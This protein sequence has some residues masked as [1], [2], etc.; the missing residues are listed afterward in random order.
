MADLSENI[1][2]QFV[3]H[4]VIQAE[5]L[6]FCRSLAEE[7]GRTLEQT[8]V[9]EGLISEAE[10]LQQYAQKLGMEFFEDLGARRVS[11]LFLN[12]VPLQFARQNALVGLMNGGGRL[13]VATS[14]PLELHPLDDLS[15]MLNV[16]FDTVLAT[17]PQIL[18][19]INQTY[20]QGAEKVGQMVEEIREEDISRLSAEISETEDLLDIANKAPV[21]KLVNTILSQANRN[22]AS[23][24][25][26]QPYEEKVVVRYRIDGLLDDYQVLPRKV[27]DAL[28]SR[29]KV[30]GRMDIAE[31]RFPQDGRATVRVAGHELDLRISSI[32]T[33]HGERIVLR[34]LD[35]SSG[36]F[37][38]EEIGLDEKHLEKLGTLIRFNHGIMLVTG[39]TGSGKT[40]TLYAALDRINTKE[41]NIITIE[42][43]IEYQ[44]SGISQ[45][46]VNEKKGLTFAEG[47]RSVLRQDPDVMMVGEIR[48]RDTASVA[49]QCALTGHLVFSTLHTND[50]PSAT[51]RL[52]DIGVEPYLVSSSV[53]AVMAQR[54]VRVICPHCKTGT[55]VDKENLDSIGLKMDELPNGEVMVGAGCDTC[56]GTGYF[57][58]TGLYELLMVDDAVRDQI[59]HRTGASM[60]KRQAV[61]CGMRTLRMDGAEKVK[62]GQTTVDE[63]LR[64]TQMD[65][66]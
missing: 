23:D 46:Q 5:K 58:R 9:E 8:V 31:R 24:V 27:H 41:K 50:A 36:L 52:L 62:R 49:I 43:P 32:P 56:R 34:F 64:V 53:I 45:M 39:P 4:G 57:G 30:M 14:S 10:I 61:S 26:I 7:T 29:I 59:M 63:V 42:D 55:L 15:R 48:D 3:G 35:K 22:R 37:R 44:L 38:L 47:L 20:P 33:S 6:D 28:V 1:L 19:L 65:V 2:E 18:Q 17:R 11:H 51:T 40:T 21:I 12:H 60:I 54:L 25:H 66:F 16:E 13:E